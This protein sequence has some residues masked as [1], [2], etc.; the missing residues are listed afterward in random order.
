MSSEIITKSFIGLRDLLHNVQSKL[1]Q[2]FPGTYWVKAEVAGIRQSGQHL[3]FELIELLN[4][5]KVAQVKA[6][7][8]AG[9]G[10]LAI[11]KFENITGQR[12][13]NGIRIGAQVRVNFHPVFGMS[14]V[15]CAIDAELT[16]GGI[17][18]QRKNT[19]EKL[20]LQYPSVISF[21]DGRYQTAN[22]R[23]P[24]KPVLQRI[25]LVT[26]VGSDGYQDFMHCIDTNRF[27]YHFS[28][29]TYSTVVHGSQ[30][31]K[32]IIN[33]FN[34]IINSRIFYDAIVLIRGGGSPADFMPFDDEHLAMLIARCTIPVITG[35]GHHTNQGIC[36][37]FSRVHTKTPTM[38]GQFLIDHNH[39]FE[40]A[41]MRLSQQL[42]E[43]TAQIIV[44]QKMSQEKLSLK[45]TEKSKYYL[46]NTMLNIN[47]L[48]SS[49]QLATRKLLADNRAGL[50]SVKHQI[51]N[52]STELVKSGQ[53]FLLQ[54]TFVF[55]QEPLRLVKAERAKSMVLYDQLK[56]RLPQ[57]IR[58]Q[59]TD[60]LR[61][62]QNFS[63]LSPENILKRGFAIIKKDE[64]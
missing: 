58:S 25:A 27:Q 51:T 53:Y 4:G 57:L 12:F 48:N 1:K 31:A 3:Y 39:L 8:F 16:L 29:D 7:A 30:A 42:I 24:L 34:N 6:N 62:Q 17:E 40:T 38:A 5:V 33:A 32:S 64:L 44:Q 59:L 2:A 9:E 45:I 19:L 21:A 54:K 55:R 61:L 26:S 18:L 23:S 15:L 35:I 50:H 37:F 56:V 13:V 20:L 46:S 10:T 43:K 11:K 14:L 49:F 22:T 60:L 28:T 47:R 63:N 36:D 52:K 41:L